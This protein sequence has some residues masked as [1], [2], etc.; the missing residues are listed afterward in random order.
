VFSAYVQE[1]ETVYAMFS[2]AL[3][4]AIE[5][6]LTGDVA[7]SC[8]AVWVTPDLCSRLAAPL[9]AL[10][11]SLDEHAKHYGTI[12]N[13]APLD[14]CNFQGSR[15]QRAAKISDL[16]SR[17]LLTHRSQFLYKIGTL[18]EMV[19]D[20]GQ[21]FRTAAE[22]LSSGSSIQPDEDWTTVDAAHY[23]MN[24]CLREVVVLLKSFFVVLPEDQLV[25]FQLTVW[26]QMQARRP[27]PSLHSKQV[28]RHGRLTPIAG[29]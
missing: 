17:V 14:P 5:L 8:Q 13:A 25:A 1:L 18:I 22:K 24:T 3:D 4:E 19:E 12:P 6:R 15:E 7:K 23:D 21:D 20:I 9:T 16:L 11:R 27:K 2:I 29:E 10:L 26:T 28:A